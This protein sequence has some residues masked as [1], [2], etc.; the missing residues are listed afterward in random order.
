[1][2]VIFITAR[3][4]HEEIERLLSLGAVGIVAKPFNP[5]TLAAAVKAYLQDS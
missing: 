5:R 3:S 4:Q 2:P 1:V